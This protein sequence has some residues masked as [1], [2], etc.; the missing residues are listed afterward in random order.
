MNST[1]TLT[2]VTHSCVLIDFGGVTLLT[3]PWFSEK[4]GYYRSEPLGIALEDLPPLAGVLVSHGHYDHYD[5]EAFKA[6]RDKTVP[7]VVKRGIGG[8]ARKAGFQQISELDPWETN[9]LGPV[10]VTAVPG[11]HGVPEI[12]YM[13]EAG[14]FTIYFGGDTRLIPAL[15]EIP[16]RFPKIDLALLAINGLMIRPA[17]NRRD[18]MSAQEAA[19]LCAIIHPRVAI[20]THYAFTGGRIMDRLLLKYNGTPEEFTAAVSQH[21]PETSVK[22]LA[23]GEPFVLKGA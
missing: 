22:V 15:R 21:A 23:P 13:L 3:D 20:P 7:F 1:V 6:Y 19:E 17:F 10:K 5:M 4:F 8:A 11:S 2:R 18:V 14:G 12:T 16:Q 9:Q